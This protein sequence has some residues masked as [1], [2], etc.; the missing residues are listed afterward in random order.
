[1]EVINQSSAYLGQDT[2][3]RRRVINN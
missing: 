2:E 1:M 3:P